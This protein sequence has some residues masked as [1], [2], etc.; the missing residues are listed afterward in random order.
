MKAHICLVLVLCAAWAVSANAIGGV[1]I[2]DFDTGNV[3]YTGPNNSFEPTPTVPGSMG[4]NRATNLDL[5]GTSLEINDPGGTLNSTGFLAFSNDVGVQGTLTMQ[6]DA[7]SP[8][9]DLTNLG[10]DNAFEFVFLN[11]D[12]PASL[13]LD[14]TDDIGGNDVVM[15]GVG[16]GLNFGL[17]VLFSSFSGVDFTKI[18]TVTL[19]LTPVNDFGGDYALD[20]LESTHV[21]IVPE[22]AGLL[23]LAGGLLGVKARKRRR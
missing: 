12:Q 23:L 8:G 22:P 2:D 4:G 3:I 9:V 1:V 7:P 17:P 6:W 13:F 16:T 15:E 19:T 18:V 5:Q 20:L 11:S 14:V 21:N 10:A